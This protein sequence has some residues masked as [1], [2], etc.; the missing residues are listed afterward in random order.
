MSTPAYVLPANVTG[1][2]YL[3]SHVVFVRTNVQGTASISQ[4]HIKEG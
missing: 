4:W 3:Q 1:Q 2:R